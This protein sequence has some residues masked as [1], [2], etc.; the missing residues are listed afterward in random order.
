MTQFAVLA[1]VDVYFPSTIGAEADRGHSILTPLIPLA[2][3]VFVRAVWS[4]PR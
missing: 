3:R 1:P 2:G 4:G